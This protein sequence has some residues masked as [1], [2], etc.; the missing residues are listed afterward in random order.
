MAPSGAGLD[1]EEIAGSGDL[2][3]TKGSVAE[4]EWSR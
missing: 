1:D 3:D 4:S 2:E